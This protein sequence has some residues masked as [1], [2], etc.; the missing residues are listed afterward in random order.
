MFVRYADD[1]VIM[2]RD[3]NLIQECKEIISKFLAERGLEL[4]VAKTKIVYTRIPFENN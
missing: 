4:S 1:F 2:N 3:L